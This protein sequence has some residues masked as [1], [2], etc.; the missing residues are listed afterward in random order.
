LVTVTFFPSSR[1][2]A[3]FATTMT[4]TT[5]APVVDGPHDRIVAD[6]MASI[7]GPADR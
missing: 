1:A 2:T 6:V 4:M 3:A 5:P 7:P